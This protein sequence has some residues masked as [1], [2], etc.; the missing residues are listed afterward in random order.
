[1]TAI[2]K[3]SRDWRIVEEWAKSQLEHHRAALEVPHTD[4]PLTEAH[5][6]TI[7][8]LNELL[9]LPDTDPQ[10]PLSYGETGYGMGTDIG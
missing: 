10:A 3:T 5:R 9:A 6:A 2:N 4:L 7:K 8:I 1:M